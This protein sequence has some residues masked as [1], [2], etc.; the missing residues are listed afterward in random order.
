MIDETLQPTAKRE[1]PIIQNAGITVKRKSVFT[2]ARFSV[3]GLRKHPGI[4]TS[5]TPGIIG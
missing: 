2:P 3:R 1:Q 4:Q 5:T